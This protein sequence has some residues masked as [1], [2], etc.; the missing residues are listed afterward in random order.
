M[1]P[2]S[3]SLKKNIIWSFSGN[4]IYNASQWL[5]VVLI[6]KFLDVYAVGQYGLALAITSPVVMFTNMQLRTVV[7]TDNNNDYLVSEYLKSRILTSL[8]A[9]V[10]ILLITLSLQKSND[11]LIVV[12][13]IAI[14]KFFESI[15]DLIFGFFQKLERMDIISKSL[16]IKSCLVLLSIGCALYFFNNLLFGLSL[17]I[18][19]LV[20]VLI[21]FDLKNF[22]SFRD[23][24]LSVTYLKSSHLTINKW[25]IKRFISLIKLAL[26]LGITSVIFSIN[27]YLPRYYLQLYFDESAVG[28]Y[29][30]ISYLNLIGIM[31]ITAIGQSALSRLSK[32][33]SSSKDEFIKLLLKMLC[34]S[35]I[36]GLFG[37]FISFV[38]GSKILTIFYKK[39]YSIYNFELLILSFAGIFW[40]MAWSLNFGINAI[41]RYREQVPIFITVLLTQFIAQYLLTPRLGILGSA[42]AMTISSF[43]LFIFFI[44]LTIKILK[45]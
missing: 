5:I 12:L 13:L 6:S 17:T 16:G 14:Y 34:I 35:F 43:I 42:I 2:T 23:E 25:F 30:A 7:A 29:T 11:L 44:L 20:L 8:L 10:L 39:E 21:F 4:V 1:K 26:P 27:T 32:L 28:Y 31:L 36:I 45:Q 3:I 37:I 15:S 19:S 38:W 24:K 18:A 33:F 9:I 40:Y 41:R 22:L